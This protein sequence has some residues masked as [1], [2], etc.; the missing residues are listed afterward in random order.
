MLGDDVRGHGGGT[1]AVGRAWLK[2]PRPPHRQALSNHTSSTP[3]SLQLILGP[4]CEA[5]RTPLLIDWMAMRPPIP[6]ANKQAAEMLRKP[7]SMEDMY[8]LSLA[9]PS[10]VIPLSKHNTQSLVT[11]VSQP[12]ECNS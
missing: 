12:S 10:I 3:S 9:C 2:L 1:S 4:P 8:S 5:V 7:P 11:V 6:E